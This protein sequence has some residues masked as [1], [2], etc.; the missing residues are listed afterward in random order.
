MSTTHFYFKGLLDK[1]GIKADF[2][3]IGD[4][5]SAPESFMREGPTDVARADSQALL[6]ALNAQLVHGI[7]AGR[8]LQTSDVESRIAN[9]PFVSSE[10]KQVGFIDQFAY[11][12]QIEDEVSKLLGHPTP[13]VDDPLATRESSQFASVRRVAIVYVEGDMID[14]KSQTIP[15]VGNRMVGSTTIGDTLRQLRADP[16]VGAIVL[17]IE[18][19]GGSALAADTLWREI[20]LTN[21]PGGKPVIVSMGGVAASGGYYVAAPATRVFAN[22]ATITGSIGI[23]YGKAD[24]AE[25]LHRIGVGTETFKTAPRADAE[26]MFRPYTEEERE[27]LQRKVRQFY[28]VFLNRVSLG[29]HL[30]HDLVDKLGQG[31]VY[32]GEQAM[33]IRLVDELGGLRQALD[34]ARKLAGLPE[35]APVVELP[36]PDSSLIGRLLGLD[37][38]SNHAT[39]PMPKPLLDM[40][41]ALAPFA[42]QEQDAPLA[43]LEWVI[44]DR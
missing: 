3:R 6:N 21:V 18:S 13:I 42:V 31:R 15:L 29:R 35:Y 34:Y 43:R 26:S 20:Q 16:N 38:V 23:F 37:G 14:G 4:H 22:P 1:L 44:P 32:T 27:E 30:P 24:V 8:H 11:S 40:A 5:K 39:I 9:G 41:R 36:V 10:A 19:P 33:K 12:D 7:A 17:R 2:V 28:E 25:L